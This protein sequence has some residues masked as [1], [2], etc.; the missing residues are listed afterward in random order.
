VTSSLLCPAG[1]LQQHSSSIPVLT[2]A[3]LMNRARATLR[4]MTAVVLAAGIA[5]TIVATSAEPERPAEWPHTATTQPVRLERAGLKQL[6]RLRDRLYCGGEPDPQTG[7]PSLAALGVKTIVSV[8]GAPPSVEAAAALGLRYVHLP[9]SYRDVPPDRLA[10]LL[11]VYEQLPG[12]IYVHCHR[13]LH[14]GPAAAVA[15]CRAVDSSL[16]ADAGSQLIKAL[17]TSPKYPGLYA[18]VERDTKVAL[19]DKIIATSLPARAEVPPLVASM[20][21]LEHDFSRFE[22]RRKSQV[23]WDDEARTEWVQLVEQLRESGRLLERSL[24]AGMTTDSASNRSLAK[25]LQSDAD[26]VEAIPSSQPGP[27]AALTTVRQRCDA[28]HATYRN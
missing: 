6:V 23:A 28:C 16:T 24:D 15:L 5:S 19:Q 20:A 1:R 3:T 25:R 10:Q 4:W 12:P 11:A 18:A 7:L 21:E 8:D 26:L 27:A 9:I 14:R 13:G 22:S 17:G 2:A